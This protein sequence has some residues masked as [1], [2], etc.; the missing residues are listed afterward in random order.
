VIDFPPLFS[1]TPP[2]PPTPGWLTRSLAV[3]MLLLSLPFL[4]GS[5]IGLMQLASVPGSVFHVLGAAFIGLVGLVLA[6]LLWTE[7]DRPRPLSPGQ[8]HSVSSPSAPFRL[9]AV[10]SITLAIPFLFLFL[11]GLA[12]L[13][14]PQADSVFV[15][16]CGLIAVGLGSLGRALWYSNRAP[17]WILR[18]VAILFVVGCVAAAATLLFGWAMGREPDWVLLLL[19]ATVPLWGRDLLAQLWNRA[20]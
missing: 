6:R 12:N 10:L 3:V 9:L 4:V 8:T 18:G 11:I 1:E 2:G 7:P 15:L 13:R 5:A 17:L 14:H 20:S 19:V 16:V